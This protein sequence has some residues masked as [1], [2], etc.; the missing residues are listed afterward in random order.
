MASRGLAIAR[1]LPQ[2]YSEAPAAAA[3][4]RRAHPWF[5][6]EPMPKIAIIGEMSAKP[7]QFDTYLAKM[8][9]HARA[10]RKEPG[11]VRFDVVVPQKGENTL[12][13]YEI[14]KDSA[15]LDV[16]ANSPRMKAYREATKDL[17]AGRKITMCHLHDSP[18]A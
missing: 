10:S 18:D 4:R 9:E 1:Q 14:W 8:T 17:Q 2:T 11:C 16:H 15:A 7:G 3:R 13:I 5:P 12:L 6:E